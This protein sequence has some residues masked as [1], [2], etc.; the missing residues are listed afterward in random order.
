MCLME[1]GDACFLKRKARIHIFNNIHP[2]VNLSFHC[3]SKD[4]DLGKQVLGYRGSY[5]FHFCP[6]VFGTTL[7]FC[8]FA[9]EGGQ[10]LWF[11]I[12]TGK[13]DQNCGDC[14]WNINPSGPCWVN[15]A[16]VLK[17]QL[18]YPWKY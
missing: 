7:F 15:T 11:D 10:S 4:N 8:S 12:Y 18:C 3:K 16:G 2:G 1:M 14:T 9:W 17:T 5:S 6:N 13:R